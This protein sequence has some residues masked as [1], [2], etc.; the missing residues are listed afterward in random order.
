MPI[1]S[2]AMV[3]LIGFPP[4]Q[5]DNPAA[6]DA[7]CLRYKPPVRVRVTIFVKG[8]PRS[9]SEHSFEHAPPG[10]SSRPRIFQARYIL[11]PDYQVCIDSGQPQAS[12]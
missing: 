10:S 12:I 3:Y 9:C 2:F 8:S 1:D 11:N 7:A 5:P 6:S 4:C